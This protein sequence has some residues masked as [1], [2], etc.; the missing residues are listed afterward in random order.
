MADNA[1][2]VIQQMIQQPAI[3]K[4]VEGWRQ[5]A[6]TAVSKDKSKDNVNME[7]EELLGGL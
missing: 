5:L 2:G 7:D 6:T 1:A 4:S 3:D